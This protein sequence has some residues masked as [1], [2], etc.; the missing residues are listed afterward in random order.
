MLFQQ[1]HQAQQ[2]QPLGRSDMASMPEGAEFSSMATPQTVLN[3]PMD[4][5]YQYPQDG[6]QTAFVQRQIQS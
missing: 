1:Q 5:A 2:M 4:Q 3:G 6:G